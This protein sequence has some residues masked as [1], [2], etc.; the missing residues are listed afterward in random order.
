MVDHQA[1]KKANGFEVYLLLEFCP[2]G[3]LFDLIESNCKQGLS[4]ISDE[5]T[6]LRILNDI[7][8]GLDYLHE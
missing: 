7:A 4:G 8:K 3:T 2:F 5:E 1:N 6:L